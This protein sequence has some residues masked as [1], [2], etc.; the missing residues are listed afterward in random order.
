[1]SWWKT[2]V[3]DEV[4]TKRKANLEWYPKR[5]AFLSDDL[6]GYPDPHTWTILM[7]IKKLV[8]SMYHSHIYVAGGFAAFVA[9]I[10]KE[11]RDI[12]LFCD[13]P[14]IFDILYRIY[15]D[16]PTIEQV[17]GLVDR[18]N[19]GRLWK[20]QKDGQGFDLVDIHP[21]VDLGPDQMTLRVTDVLSSFD[22]NWAMAAITLVDNPKIYIHPEALSGDVR[23]N[24]KN[25][26]VLQGTMKRIEK[27]MERLVRP[28]NKPY[29]D[30]MIKAL[31]VHLTN[32][33]IAEDCKWNS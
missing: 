31:G 2:K 23:V 28:V 16:D 10:T 1:M 33:L 3:K 21:M 12:D 27:Y 18:E 24:L 11:Y 32:D 17:A 13:S 6:E 19:Y 22:I 20:F 26:K 29:A 8:P 25:V 14:E 4:P 15:F 9:G 5:E 30:Q 7:D